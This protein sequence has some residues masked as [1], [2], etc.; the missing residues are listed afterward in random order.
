VLN[1][2]LIQNEGR[3]AANAGIRESTRPRY[4][5]PATIIEKNADSLAVNRV[6]NGDLNDE[7]GVFRGSEVMAQ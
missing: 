1:G 2:Q 7:Q 6:L 4:S 5:H 3:L